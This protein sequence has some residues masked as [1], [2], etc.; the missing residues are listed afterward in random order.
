[1][2]ASFQTSF[3]FVLLLLTSAAKCLILCTLHSA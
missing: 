2:S 1:M 3:N